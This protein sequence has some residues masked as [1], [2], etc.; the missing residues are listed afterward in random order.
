MLINIPEPLITPRSLH[1]MKKARDTAF[2]DFNR[3]V[4]PGGLTTAE[5]RAFELTETAL[6]LL[7]VAAQ[8]RLDAEKS[9]RGL[10]KAEGEHTYD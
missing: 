8:L 6:R 7:I 4:N 5:Q 9:M 10:L 2:E 3:H 1:T